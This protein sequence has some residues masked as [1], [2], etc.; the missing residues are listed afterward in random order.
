MSSRNYKLILTVVAVVALVVN[1]FNQNNLNVKRESLG[2]TRLE[3]LENA[4][5]MLAF[6]TV[7]LGGFRGLIV[8][9][10]FIRSNQL[11]GKGL[12][13]E[14]MTLGD[15]ITKLQPTF[16]PVWRFQAWNMA[17]NISR[18]FEYPKDRWGWVWAGIKLMRDE[19]L[20]YNPT[21]PE[22]Y[23]ELG[24]FFYDKIGRYSETEH[25]AYKRIFHEMTEEVFPTGKPDLD[26]LENPQTDAEKESARLL[27]DRFKMDLKYIRQVE[28]NFGPLDWRLPEA[29]AIYWA[30]VGM[31]KATSGDPMVMFRVIWQSMQMS[32][33][34]GTINVNPFDDR[35]EFSPNLDIIPKVNQT[36]E[37]VKGYIPDRADYVARGQETFLHEAIYLLYLHGRRKEAAEW[38]HYVRTAIPTIQYTWVRDMPLDQFVMLNIQRTVNRSSPFRSKAVIEAYLMNYFYH[39]AVGQNSR[40]RGNAL[41]AR[42]TYDLY[43]ERFSKS[44]KD[45][46]ALSSFEQIRIGVLINCLSGQ[47]RF[48]SVMGQRLRV[49]LGLPEDWRSKLSKGVLDNIDEKKAFNVDADLNPLNAE[50]SAGDGL[51]NS[52]NT[53]EK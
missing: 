35:I 33:Q 3:P 7:A 38:Y 28:E 8:N 52:P 17:Y 26:G 53:E 39:L 13:F 46:Q 42:K 30:T 41:F 31:N 19:G 4:P 29:H 34:R 1:S 50:T 22:M 24:W 48:T 43:H 6:T 11:Q 23:R 49:R 5:P 12:Y 25:F 10:L 15:W 47:G 16:T 36:Y 44:V 14:T 40:A 51:D 32:F 45:I 27:K 20:K 2:L 9:F 18:V 37:I 21:D